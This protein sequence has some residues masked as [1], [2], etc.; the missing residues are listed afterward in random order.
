MDG[1][2]ADEV[3]ELDASDGDLEENG[4]L[5]RIHHESHTSPHVQSIQKPHARINTIVNSWGELDESD[6]F[7]PDNTLDNH[8]G[9]GK[10]PPQQPARDLPARD[11]WVCVLCFSIITISF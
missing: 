7:N 4:A 9:R 3:D 11:D 6:A 8:N 1:S 2:A 10:P 5:G